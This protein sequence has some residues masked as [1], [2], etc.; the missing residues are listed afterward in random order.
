M[1]RRVREILALGADVIAV[2]TGVG[3]IVS[4]VVGVSL[5]ASRLVPQP[6]LSILAAGVFLLTAGIAGRLFADRQR[7]GASIVPLTADPSGAEKAHP[8]GQKLRAVSG[9]TLVSQVLSGA[10]YQHH[11]IFGE[12]LPVQSL[13]D[14]KLAEVALLRRMTTRME[15]KRSGRFG[16]EKL[17]ENLSARECEGILIAGGIADARHSIVRLEGRHLIRSADAGEIVLLGTFFGESFTYCLTH[18]PVLAAAYRKV[19]LAINKV[20][21]LGPMETLVPDQVSYEQWLRSLSL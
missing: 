9:E 7:H 21:R 14:L 13:I 15:R 8:L 11:D 18:D 20:I 2:A 10:A 3:L 4:A 12:S 5:Q 6:W 17:S 16:Y 1:S 19:A